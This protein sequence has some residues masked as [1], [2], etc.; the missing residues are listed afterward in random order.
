M[1]ESKIEWTDVT[2]NPLAGCTYVS[3]GCRFCYAATM[4]RR[5][6][7]MGQADY[8]GLTTSKHFNGTIRLRPDK[9]AKPLK[10]R[11]P[12]RVFVNSMCD[13]FHKDVPDEFIAAVFG[14]MAACPLHTFQILTKRADRLASW[15]LA[16][17]AEGGIGRYIRDNEDRRKVFRSVFGKVQKTAVFYGK[18]ERADDDP[19]MLVMNA[20][21]CNYGKAPLSNVWLGV[22]VENQAAANERIPHLLRTP[23]A[24]R[25]LS[26]EPLIAPVDL[27]LPHRDSD[28]DCT[29]CG[30]SWG[31]PE[32]TLEHDCPPGFGPRLDWVICGG[33][34]GPGSRPCDIE[35]IRNIVRQ[36]KEAETP[37]FVKQLGAMIAMPNDSLSEWPRGGDELVCL[38]SADILPMQGDTWRYRLSDRKGGDMEEWPEDLR[39]REYPTPAA[40]RG[41]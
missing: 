4:T 16:V 15:S 39:V 33:E 3:E 2:W 21:A 25:F 12:R 29:R 24:V 26:C 20:A 17:Q 6:E 13:L 32:E 36:C 23:A 22:S 18:T 14:I 35:W 28:G 9:L 31:P 7:A 5:L 40:C 8:A 30:C 34:S 11:K 1:S 41:A 27:K 10:W 19:W 37:C 38:E